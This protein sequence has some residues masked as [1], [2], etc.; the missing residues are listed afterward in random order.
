MCI[1]TK[2]GNKYF[3]NGESR[4]LG[5]SCEYVQADLTIEAHCRNVVRV[6]DGKFG[7]VHGLVNAA[8]ITDRGNLE[9]TTVEL[10]D[11]LFNTNVRAPFM[12]T[13]EVVKIM[14]REKI[15]SSIVNIISDTAHG[16]P[17]LLWHIL[18]QRERWQP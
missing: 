9:D 2:E 13:Q 16:G 18:P 6:C 4:E 17:L 12:L 11:R 8:G 5:C 15:G 10:W 3:T 14:S 7:K 1:R